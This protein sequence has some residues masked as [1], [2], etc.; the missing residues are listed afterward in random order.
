[1][2][3]TAMAVLLLFG[4]IPRTDG[5]VLLAPDALPL[6]AGAGDLG[7]MRHDRETDRSGHA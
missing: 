1:M 4:L 2:V 6:A 7:K 5:P 3:T